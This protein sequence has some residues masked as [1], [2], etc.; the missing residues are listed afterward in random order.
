MGGDAA[1]VA[2]APC[3]H[4][5]GVE[6]PRRQR[7]EGALVVSSGD[8]LVLK[9]GVVVADQNHV[10]V[11]ISCCV[12]P[13]HL[14]TAQELKQLSANRNTRLFNQFKILHS[15]VAILQYHLPKLMA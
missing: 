5:D 11:Q 4:G 8:A 1:D 10:A 14:Q 2:A 3:F 12:M 9:D 13:V 6:S 15:F 7:R